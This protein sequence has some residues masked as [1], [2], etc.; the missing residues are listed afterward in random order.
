MRTGNSGPLRANRCVA[1]GF[2]P[3]SG[4]QTRGNASSCN[5]RVLEA[6]VRMPLASESGSPYVPGPSPGH[7]LR[8]DPTVSGVCGQDRADT[9]I[10][11]YRTQ[12]ELSFEPHENR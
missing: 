4:F 1:P 3:G 11:A 8:I 9:L 6:L 5:E 12:R 10:V 2:S 7:E